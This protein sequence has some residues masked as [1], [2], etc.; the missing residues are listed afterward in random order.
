MYWKNRTGLK[1]I[2]MM[3]SV[4]TGSVDTTNSHCTDDELRRINYSRESVLR[5]LKRTYKNWASSS[6][7]KWFGKGTAYS[8]E[9]VK[10]RYKFAMDF[11]ANH[12]TTK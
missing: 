8:N 6:F 3:N 9:N 10:L 11:M 1:D 2:R 12:R 7:T 4:G 5:V